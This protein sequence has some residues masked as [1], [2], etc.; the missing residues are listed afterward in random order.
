MIKLL[1]NTLLYDLLDV[2]ITNKHGK[3]C[4]NTLYSITNS[5]LRE[6]PENS[7]TYLLWYET[8]LILQLMGAIS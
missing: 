5:K 2:Y 4:Y 6:L 7:E 1:K 8:K 3:F